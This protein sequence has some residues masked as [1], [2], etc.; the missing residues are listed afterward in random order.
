M[1]VAPLHQPDSL[2]TKVRQ[3]CGPDRVRIYGVCV[4]RDYGYRPYGYTAIA[5][6]PMGITVTGD[7]DIMALGPI[8]DTGRAVHIVDGTEPLPKGISSGPTTYALGWYSTRRVH[9]FNQC[10]AT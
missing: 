3:G 2:I 4:T 6:V 10:A 1:P 5:T 9:V 7:T 8:A